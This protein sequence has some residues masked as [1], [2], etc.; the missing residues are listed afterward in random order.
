MSKRK[1]SSR[2]RKSKKKNH[3][4]TP[5]KETSS[6][7]LELVPQD[8][9][10]PEKLYQ[11]SRYWVF[12]FTTPLAAGRILIE[13]AIRNKDQS[14]KHDWREFQRIKNELLGPEEEAV[15]LY[16]A[17]SR[18]TDT[19]NEFHL[20]CIR[21]MQFPFGWNEREVSEASERQRPWPD[22]E[23]PNELA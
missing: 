8:A 5:F 4:W 1:T 3:G 22:G 14:A 15:E 13:L 12:L 17:E 21:G 18:L 2:A 10:K 16:P 9:K 20:W 11:N 6:I 23:K 7:L 19:K